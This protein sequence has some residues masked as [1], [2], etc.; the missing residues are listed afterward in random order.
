MAEPT[1]IEA[2]DDVA[3]RVVPFAERSARR[4][5][6]ELVGVR[7]VFERGAWVMRI[8]IDREEGVSVEDCAAVSRQL[9]TLLDVEDVV[10]GAYNLEVTSPGLDQELLVAA[11]YQRYAGRR[12]RV[13][14]REDLDGRRLVHGLLRGLKRGTVMMDDEDGR[15]L[16]FPLDAVSDARLEVEI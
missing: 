2:N 15:R 11:D 10:P 9:S 5:G 14:L 8:I 4:C 7:H 13:A 6:C 16:E 3:G 12:V 1:A